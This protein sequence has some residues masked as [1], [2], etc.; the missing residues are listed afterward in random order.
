MAISQS[1]ARLCLALGKLQSDHLE[2][3]LLGCCPLACMQVAKDM[4]SPEQR[5]LLEGQRQAAALASAV[6]GTSAAG[7]SGST[8]AQLVTVQPKGPPQAASDTVTNRVDDSAGARGILPS[9]CT[10]TSQSIGVASQDKVQGPVKPRGP[11]IVDM[12]SPS[13]QQAVTLGQA[14][15]ALG[16]V[17]FGVDGGNS[18]GQSAAVHALQVRRLFAAAMT[19]LIVSGL[20]AGN[21]EHALSDGML[22][23]SLCPKHHMKWGLGAGG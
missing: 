11:L 10:S 22:L 6:Q 2:L 19:D 12:G 14:Q 16:S 3:A 20:H 23:C 8:L 4:M 13:E 18:Q 7:L 9:A 21:L 17:A 15:Q 5:T 1:G